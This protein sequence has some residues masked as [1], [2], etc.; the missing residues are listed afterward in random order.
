LADARQL[1]GRRFILIGDYQVVTH[2]T[3]TFAQRHPDRVTAIGRLRGDAN[4]YAPPANPRRRTRGGG[5][6]RKGKKIAS[7]A[8]RAGQL[9]PAA[10]QQAA[11]QWYGGQ[12]RSVTWVSETALWYDKHPAQ[13]TPIRW[14]CVLGDQEA[15]LEN[16][17]FF[18]SDQAMEP[19][20][21]IELYA[22]RWNIE[23]T[24]AK[25]PARCWDWRPRGIGAGRR[26]CG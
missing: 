26:C 7:P 10:R 20:R 11:I 22:S 15:G 24:F 17:C 21:L 23:V 8:E 3:V 18:S 9:A 1:P 19:A 6:A 16:A 13:V 5:V 14:V 4:L 2:E 12:T 25:K